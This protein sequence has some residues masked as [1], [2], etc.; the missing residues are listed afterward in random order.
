MV[1]LAFLQHSQI[2]TIFIVFLFKLMYMEFLQ[3]SYVDAV[4]KGLSVKAE[5]L[6]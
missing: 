3:N 4:Y 5:G 1:H 2:D 6:L